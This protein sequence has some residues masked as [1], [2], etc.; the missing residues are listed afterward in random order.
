MTIKMFITKILLSVIVLI[1][2]LCGN[3]WFGMS[4][5]R[6]FL[7]ECA[8]LYAIFG[9]LGLLDSID[10]FH[11]DQENIREPQRPAIEAV[12]SGSGIY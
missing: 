8:K 12:P 11:T 9:P 5:F 7:N 4:P 6:L 1:Q 2:A 10:D 3:M